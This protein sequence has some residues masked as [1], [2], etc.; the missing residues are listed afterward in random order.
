MH[1][2]KLISEGLACAPIQ[3]ISEGTDNGKR[4]LFIEGIFAQAE[5]KN[6]NKRIYPKKI[7][8]SAVDKYVQN[9]VSMDRA[10]GEL[11]H[12]AYPMP[13]P[14]QACILIKELKWNGNDVYGKAK[15][16]SSEKGK[17]LAALINDGVRFGVSTRGV[18]SITE[19]ADVGIVE[20][21]YAINA[22]D[23]VLMPS[24]I[25]CFV[26]GVTEDTIK[27]LAPD[28]E[29]YA[30][31]IL[32]HIEFYYNENNELTES[33]CENYLKNR[34]IGDVKKIQEDFID[35]LSKISF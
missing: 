6:R 3:V 5:K 26:N 10:L 16:L 29:K 20:S 30:D 17:T 24:G 31:G 34:K 27:A 8:E 33:V 21:D 32:E 35:F 4:S 9:Y 19:K 14:A 15:V 12:P 28:M 22:I 18:G 25:D 7:L 11:N 13:D 23:V 1:M 2:M